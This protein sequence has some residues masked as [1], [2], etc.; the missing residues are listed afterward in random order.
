MIKQAWFYLTITK[1]L[2]HMKT[3]ILLSAGAEAGIHGM[4]V[5]FFFFLI[6]IVS[7]R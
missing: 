2:S 4:G 5:N 6:R 7:E 3:Y 1:E